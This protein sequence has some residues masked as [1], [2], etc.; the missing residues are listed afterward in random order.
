MKYTQIYNTELKA[1][2]IAL[3]CMRLSSLNEKQADTLIGTALEQGINSFDH[4]DIYGG[5]KSEEIFLPFCRT[6]PA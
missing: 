3:G 2:R 5:G 6:I 4:A 1:S